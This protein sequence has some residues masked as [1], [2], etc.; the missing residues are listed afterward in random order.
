[1]PGEGSVYRRKSD[2][3]WVAALS[4]GPRDDRVIRRRYARS[5]AEAQ[6]E[7]QSMRTEA[8]PTTETV[9]AYL[10]RWVNEARGIRPTTRHAYSAAI[11]EHLAPAIGHIRLAE[12]TAVHVEQVLVQV[13]GRRSPKTARNVH[14]TLRRALGQAVRAGVLT[15]NVA[16]REF[17]DAPKVPVD[18]PRALSEAE[19]DRLVAAAAKDR[20]GA[21]FVLAVDTGLRQGELLGLAWQDIDGA[22]LHVRR[23]LIYTKGQTRGEGTYKPGEL[24]TPRSRR[25]VPLTPRAVVALEQH[26]A[27]M[28]AE[29]FLTIDTGPVFVTPTGRAVSGSW[30][31][32]HF[33][34]LLADAGV[35]RIPFK[36]LRTTFA[37]RLDAKGVPELTIATL[38]GHTRTHTTRKHYIAQAPEA[39][40][41]AIARLAG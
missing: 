25:D 41:A 8:D 36:N 16:S 22:T 33:Y 13:E 10:E 14:G 6:R 17:V 12:L 38:M 26:R 40:A 15:K 29:G 4:E 28:K 11:R 32:H 37:S 27:T 23:E 1:M 31:T 24:K 18:E 30:L 3:R 39:G 21:L 19:V 35:E 20:L 34:D 2:G 5:R 7:L 9:G